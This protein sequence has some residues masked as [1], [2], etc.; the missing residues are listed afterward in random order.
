MAEIE[1]NTDYTQYYSEN[2]TGYYHEFCEISEER[3]EEFIE[4]WLKKKIRNA[5]P[6]HKEIKHTVFTRD[7]ERHVIGEVDKP[8]K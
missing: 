6:P 1:N 7:G 3:S 2:Y 5:V 4:K 8:Y